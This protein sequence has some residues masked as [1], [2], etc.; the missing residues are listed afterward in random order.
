MAKERDISTI[1]AEN[2]YKL[3]IDKKTTQ[4]DMADTLGVD[5]SYVSLLERGA[6]LPS[7]VTLS[8]IAAYFGVKPADLVTDYTRSS[9]EMSLKQKELF[10]LVRDS[11][12]E[13]IN[14]IYQ[15]IKILADKK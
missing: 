14:K 1:F 6:R 9:K 13:K 7:F 15:I 10:Y 3:R 5:N 12:P 11:S 4:E 2:L 8:K